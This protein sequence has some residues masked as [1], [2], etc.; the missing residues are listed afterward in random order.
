MNRSTA[1]DSGW[2]LFPSSVPWWWALVALVVGLNIGAVV[3]RYLP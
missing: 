2:S 1:D 3:T